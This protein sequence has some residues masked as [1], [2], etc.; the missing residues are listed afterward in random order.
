M[1]PAE[2]YSSSAESPARRCLTLSRSICVIRFTS[3]KTNGDRSYGGLAE[4]AAGTPVEI[5]GAG[6][7]NRSL[8]I[9]ANHREY[10]VFIR[11][12][13]DADEFATIQ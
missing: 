11:D 13:D 10:F 12:L 3:P 9:S 7:N 5:C 4:L 8:K 6:F 2:V 1:F